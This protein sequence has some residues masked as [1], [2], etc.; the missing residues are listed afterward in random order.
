M[1]AEEDESIG[2][3]ERKRAQ[4]N[5]FDEREDGGGGADSQRQ[6]ENDRRGKAR[7]LEELAQRQAQIVGESHSFTPAKQ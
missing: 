3:V 7:R 2:M 6:G 5:A 1:V 4:E